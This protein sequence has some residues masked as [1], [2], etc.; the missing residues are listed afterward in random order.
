MS[1]LKMTS[2]IAVFLLLG[3][4][5]SS[6]TMAAVVCNVPS[7]RPTI[8]AAVNDGTCDPINVAADVYNENIVINRS[9]ALYGAG[10]A[11]TFI[12]GTGTGTNI[13][14]VKI[15]AA[16]NVTLSGFT[17][18]NPPVVNND[19]LRVGVLTN[20]PIEG[21]TY[22]IVSNKIVGTN[23]P[24]AEEDYG[25]YG[26]NG[27]KE[28]LLITN[29]VVTQ[30]GSNNI[31][32]ET[33]QG[34]TDISYNSLDA[35]CYGIDA[36]FVMA[37]S[38]KDVSNLQKVHHNTIDMGTGVGVGL[39]NATGITFAAV[40]GYYGVSPARFLANSIEITNN[41]MFN[42]KERRRGIGL[43]NDATVGSDGNI[44]NPTVL[45][46]TV[47][48]APGTVT[49]SMGIYTLGL[50]TNALIT[51]N[52]ITGVDFS[53]KERSWNGHIATGTQLN[54]NNFSNNITG[55]LT[56]RSTGTLNA[57]NNWWSCAAGPGNTGCD[58]VSSNVDYAPWLT[59][60]VELIPLTF[61]WKDYNG[62]DPGGY[63]PDIDQNQAFSVRYLFD[64][65]DDDQGIATMDGW[66]S[67]TIAQYTAGIGYGYSDITPGTYPIDDRNRGVPASK[68][69]RDFHFAYSTRTFL[70]D[71]ANGTYTVT[72]HTGDKDN[73]QGPFDVN[74]EG[75]QKL[76]NVSTVA[77]EFK[78]LSFPVVVSDGQLALDFVPA[79]DNW[80][81]NG[82]EIMSV[83]PEYCAPVAEANSLWWLDKKHQLGIFEY[84]YDGLGYIGGD[85]NG[86]GVADLLDLVQ[87]LAIMMNTNQGHTGTTVLDE[88]A[89]IDAFL[90]QYGLNDQLYEHT[91]DPAQYPDWLSYFTYIEAEVE[92][93]QDVKL[94]LGFW[95]VDEAIQL[96]PNLW[97]VWWSHRGGHAVTV[98]GVD[99]QNFLL[100]ISDPDNDT[101]EAGI[102]PGVVRPVPGGH[103]AHPNDPS[104]HNNEDN[105]SHDIYT[106]GP[107]PSPGGKMGLLNFPW[108]WNLP[109]GEWETVGPVDVEW[110][111]PLEYCQTFIEIEAA[112][113]VS[114][115]ICGN[116]VVDPG[117]TC[118]P[119]G[120]PGPNPQQPGNCRATC[121]YCGDGKVN[122]AEA[123]DDGNGINNDGCTNNCTFP[124][125]G[126]SIIQPPETCDP[127]GGQWPPNGNPCRQTCT[128]CGDSQVNNDEQCDDG[129]ANNNDNC[130]NNCILNP[131]LVITSLTAPASAGAGKN[132]SIGDTTKNNGPGAAL[133]STTKFYL[134][135]NNILDGGDTLL[136]SRAVPALAANASSLGNT[137]VT[138]PTNKP[139]G[140]YFIIAMADDPNAIVEANENN[141][142]NSKA[143]TVLAVTVVKPN[144]GEVIPSGSI[145]NIQ[146]L[147]SSDAVK[148][149][150]QY[151]MNNGTTSWTT[152]VTGIAGSSYNW[153]VPKPKKNKKNC[154]VKVIGYD[155]SNVE[156]GQD[157]SDAIFTIE[158]VKVTSPNGEETWKAGE[159]HAIKWTTNGTNKLVKKVKLYYTY[160]GGTNWILIYTFL[161]SNPGT[162]SWRVP[163]ANSANCKVKVVLKDKLGTT[164]G[165]DV[166]D[167]IFTISP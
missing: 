38:G 52:T 118:D 112:V 136:G 18:V 91:A 28:N 66:T 59:Q 82:I 110:P 109:T 93:S 47:T 121:T 150:L 39:A 33:H 50:V 36:I 90:A 80:T 145:Y 3:L 157:T 20:S 40:A 142:T 166:S 149:D 69:S 71:V 62:G 159:T 83:D 41:S 68:L 100:A 72:I 1:K 42:L 85:I 97:R 107:S 31:V 151:S 35:G 86:D 29:N 26:Q 45:L 147:K 105:A 158:V 141:N 44:I 73:A 58:N 27:G 11:S 51:N 156:V 79:G 81:I 61:Y 119:P 54:Q 167:T 23:D 152:I 161:N 139:S 95:H 12:N 6:Q 10:S 70:V 22:A 113:I 63:M 108:K 15:T 101:A 99:S 75:D 137:S 7:D 111:E 74:A 60:P 94:D 56:E 87:E 123:C 98:A 163:S 116:S 104:A 125:C 146:W 120:Q 162:Y 126:D 92:R 55:V 88:Q 25:I 155:A 9:L 115:I 19:D 122:N 140:N 117:E 17:I 49:A 84:P 14:V 128:Y 133:A 32:I 132:I 129:N 164:I 165:S 37:H 2:L 77:G 96:G 48:G 57:E 89:G 4:L 160:N 144:G 124:N 46:N 130:N 34:K 135:V 78:A 13:S 65:D 21:V 154:L 153:T 114:P 138:I 134:S 16:G 106:V 8:Q 103:P 148:F 30:T 43:W 24:D 5:I 143:I 64:F 131:D 102:N 127:L 67:F 76:D 53:L